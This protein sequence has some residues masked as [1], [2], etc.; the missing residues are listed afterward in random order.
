M[1]VLHERTEALSSTKADIVCAA[2]DTAIGDQDWR[3]NWPA[4]VC[5]RTE[6]R[7]ACA[8]PAANA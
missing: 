4:Y 8:Y 1:A 2:A 3:S 7:S 5:Q 6:L